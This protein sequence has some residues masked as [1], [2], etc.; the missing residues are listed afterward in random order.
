M[1]ICLYISLHVYVTHYVNIKYTQYKNIHLNHRHWKTYIY[2]IGL[3]S[4]IQN[5]KEFLTKTTNR[6]KSHDKWQ[7]CIICKVTQRKAALKDLSKNYINLD[8]V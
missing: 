4:S 7:G 6:T 2:K 8:P 5:K 1:H 3:C